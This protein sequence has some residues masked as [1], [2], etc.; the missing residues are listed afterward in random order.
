MSSLLKRKTHQPRVV[1][2]ITEPSV[3]FAQIDFVDIDKAIDNKLTATELRLWLYLA[4]VKPYIPSV[5]ELSPRLGMSKRSV[6]KAVDRLAELGLCEVPKRQQK[7]TKE[8]VVRDRLQSELGGLVEVAT[9]AGR[10]DLL[11]YTE[12]IEVKA[13]K[14]WKAALGQILVY[15]GFYPKHRKRIHLFG[16]ITEIERVSDIES[17]CIGFDIK[18]TGEVVQ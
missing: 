12:I 4:R 5:Q 15:S 10:I 1:E 14:D 6:E 11:T 16:S 18:V 8:V 17:A 3:G 13:F 7:T 2:T 9:P